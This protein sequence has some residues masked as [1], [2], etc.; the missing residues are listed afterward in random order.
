MSRPRF[1]TSV[2]TQ[3]EPRR[4]PYWG[5]HV[6]RYRFAVPYL[7]DRRTLDVAC[8]DGYGLPII[9]ERAAGVIG[10]DI[11]LNAARNARTELGEGP[12]QVVISDG[13]YLPFADASFD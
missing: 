3:T 9:R 12:G 13:C 6:A 11:D 10:V 5:E 8:G 7:T 2:T 4:S 1:E